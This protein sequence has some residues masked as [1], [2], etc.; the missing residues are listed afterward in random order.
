MIFHFLRSTVFKVKTAHIIYRVLKLLRFDMLRR[1]SRG[2]VTYEVDLREGID[3][4][5]FVL[6]NFQRHVVESSYFEIRD[7]AVVFEVG[8]NI[9]CVSLYIANK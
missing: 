5:L 8:A 1:I 4:S 3:L 9:G 6:G 2:G 7:D